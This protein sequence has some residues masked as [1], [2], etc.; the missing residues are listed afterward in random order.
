MIQVVAE[1]L[2][3]E[4]RTVGEATL[5]QVLLDDDSIVE[6][7][8]PVAEGDLLESYQ[9]TKDGKTFTNWRRFDPDK[10]SNRVLWEELREIRK[11]TTEM[12]EMLND[13]DIREKNGL[14]DNPSY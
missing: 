14:P 7:F 10:V 6:V 2:N 5:S 13:L 1:V 3:R 11:L 8:N 9:V 4:I 12:Y